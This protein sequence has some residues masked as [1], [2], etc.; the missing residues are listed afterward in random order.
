M[1]LLYTF[2]QLTFES[3]RLFLQRRSLRLSLCFLIE[4]WWTLTSCSALQKSLILLLWSSVALKWL[5]LIFERQDVH[6]FPCLSQWSV[7]VLSVKWVEEV[8]WLACCSVFR[9]FVSSPAKEKLD[10]LWCVSPTV[11]LTTERLDRTWR[12]THAACNFA[13]GQQSEAAISEQL[14][15]SA[16]LVILTLSWRLKGL[17]WICLLVLS[18]EVRGQWGI[19]IVLTIQQL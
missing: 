5:L 14:S 8:C 16:S 11:V 10:E 6:H 7:K 15:A 19:I 2:V 4:H 9:K 18:P 17:K 1:Y 3:Q 12:M 13:E